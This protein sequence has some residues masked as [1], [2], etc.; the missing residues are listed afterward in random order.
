MFLISVSGEKPYKCE[1]CEKSFPRKT[2]LTD[3]M[4]SHTGERPFACDQCDKRFT[5]KYILQN[6]QATIHSAGEKPFR[7]DHC[8]K[9]FSIK[10]AL[11]KHTETH[12]LRSIR[13]RIV[14]DDESQGVEE[15]PE[16]GDKQQPKKRGRGRPKK[17]R[18]KKL[19]NELTASDFSEVD[20]EEE[21][22]KPEDC[23]S[24]P[25]FVCDVRPC[26][27]DK[28]EANEAQETDT[29]GATGEVLGSVEA[30]TEEDAGML[31]VRRQP[32]RNAGKPRRSLSP[33][34]S[35]SR[36]ESK[37]KR[38]HLANEKSMNESKSTQ[39]DK[40]TLQK[41]AKRI[42]DPIN[43]ADYFY[44]KN[45]Y[46]IDPPGMPSIYVPPS[47]RISSPEYIIQL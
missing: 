41:P 23:E 29:G 3:H 22:D 32:K 5:Q 18:H 16:T 37:E 33:I 45:S 40:R 13:R 24:D 17:K 10:K 26:S 11:H 43:A 35:V 8:D 21:K 12:K 15:I 14:S 27:D 4:R 31:P 9:C 34:E 46:N 30:E 1:V 2:S 44:Y 25:D 38:N 28:E 6:H 36:K 39:R 7:C 47:D 42:V 20:E 19:I